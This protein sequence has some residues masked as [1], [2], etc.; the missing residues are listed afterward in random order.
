MY[1]ENTFRRCSTCGFTHTHPDNREN[2]AFN[3][4]KCG[5]QN[6]A[7]SNAAKNIRLRY[8]RRNQPGG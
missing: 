4:E 5:Y 6:H 3:C 1:P 2:E 8:L 7:D